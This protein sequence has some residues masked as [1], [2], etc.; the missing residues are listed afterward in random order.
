MTRLPAPTSTF[1]R[2]KW[3]YDD[4]VS[5]P[6][7]RRLVLV[8]VAAVASVSLL[9]ARE[10]SFRASTDEVAV[11]ASVRGRDGR[12][13]RGLTREEFRIREDGRPTDLLSFSNAPQ[14]VSV[15]IMLYSNLFFSGLDRV[16]HGV[17]QFLDALTPR[18]RVAVGVFG[19]ETFVSPVMPPSHPDLRRI[20]AEDLWVGGLGGQA[21]SSWLALDRAIGRLVDERNRRVLLVLHDDIGPMSCL[22]GVLRA[23]CS[24]V[25]VNTV[26]QRTEREN[27]FAYGLSFGGTMR[28]RIRGSSQPT[29][30]TLLDRAGGV[31]LPVD[32]DDD[33]GLVLREVVDELH[34]QYLLTFRPRALDGKRH[35]I[36]LEVVHPGFRVRA[37]NS[38]LASGG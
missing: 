5:Q 2:R 18:D 22:V 6:T 1:S 23:L 15:A 4:P 17:S 21:G 8:F 33:L 11:Y 38:Y 26:I 30:G 13:V 29:L 16:R 25:D 19:G 7:L 35:R 20:L 37:R 24:A 32:D 3:A 10:Q 36:A 27:V 28:A 31:S 9:A 34:Q 12:L 14:S